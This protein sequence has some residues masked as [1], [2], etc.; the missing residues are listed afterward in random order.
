MVTRLVHLKMATIVSVNVN[1]AVEIGV[2]L[3]HETQKVDHLTEH[4]RGSC[5]INPNFESHELSTHET[6]L[7]FP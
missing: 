2:C 3:M 1:V 4:S 7:I 5:D 6:V